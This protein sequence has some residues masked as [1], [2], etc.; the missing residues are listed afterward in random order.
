MEQALVQAGVADAARPEYV[1]ED[2][3]AVSPGEQVLLAP[4]TLD[5]FMLERHQAYG[6]GVRHKDRPA[7]TLDEFLAEEQ[8]RF[9]A[10]LKAQEDYEAKL[11]AGTDTH[12]DAVD[13]F[14]AT[15]VPP[16]RLWVTKPIPTGKPG[17]VKVRVATQEHGYGERFVTIIDPEALFEAAR[18]QASFDQLGRIFGVSGMFLSRHPFYRAV[19]EQARAERLQDLRTAQFDAAVKDR[20]PALL[21]WLGKQYLGQ[22]D[23]VEQEQTVTVSGPGGQPVQHQHEVRAVLVVPDNG[24]DRPESLPAGTMRQG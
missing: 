5:Q 4:I 19:I 8:A 24:R 3:E 17:V 20:N 13:T 12:Q 15:R 11:E 23:K 9:E 6:L 18:N 2:V 1:N 14:Y 22:R 7:E 10:L 21:I 16:R